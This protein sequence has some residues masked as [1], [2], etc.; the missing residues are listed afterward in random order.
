[1]ADMNQQGIKKMTKNN[2]LTVYPAFLHRFSHMSIDLQDMIVAN[3][4]IVKLYNDREEKGE[5]DLQFD[6][7]NDGQVEDQVNELIE[8]FNDAQ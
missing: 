3:P 7:Q 4:T 1:M 8:Q 5:L 6:R 2:F